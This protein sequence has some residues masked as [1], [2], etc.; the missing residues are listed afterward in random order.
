MSTIPPF[1]LKKLYVEGS[2]RDEGESFAFDLKNL[3]A[4]ATITAFDG[5]IVD[6]KAIDTAQ[7]T[8]VPSEGN[9]R[10]MDR[11]SKRS[12]LD[13]PIGA[14]VTLRVEETL[15]PGPHKLILRVSVKEIG[16]LDIPVS[17][18]LM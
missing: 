9:P 2:L 7:V 5:L 15:E 4:P 6:G 10:S 8:L 16:S 11:I 3:V 1:V 18:E 17:D 12:P 14:A 13:F